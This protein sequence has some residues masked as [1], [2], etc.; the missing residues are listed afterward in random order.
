MAY[1]ISPQVA[2]EFVERCAVFDAPLDVFIKQYWRHGQALY[3]LSPGIAEPGAHT[4]NTTISTR[5]PRQATP[6]VR[7]ARWFRKRREAVLR[8]LFNMGWLRRHWRL[9]H[10]GLPVRSSRLSEPV[11]QGQVEACRRQR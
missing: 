3:S 4:G 5:L 1:V 6:A 8:A 9:V 7:V 10:W 11:I 2:H